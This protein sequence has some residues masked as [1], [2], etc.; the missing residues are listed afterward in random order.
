MVI[1][2]VCDGEMKVSDERG[3]PLLLIT[4]DTETDSE[5][6]AFCVH[7]GNRKIIKD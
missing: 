4:G 3:T 1:C 2:D 7:C 5:R 6:L